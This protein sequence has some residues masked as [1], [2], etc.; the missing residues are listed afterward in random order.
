M[1]IC[2]NS[3]QFVHKFVLTRVTSHNGLQQYVFLLIH[4]NRF[5]SLNDLE[6]VRTF[7]RCFSEGIRLFFFPIK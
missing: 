6:V 2:D 3:I 7:D 1:F 5:E 4:L